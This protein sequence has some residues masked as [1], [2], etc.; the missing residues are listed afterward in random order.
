MGYNRITLEDVRRNEEFSTYVSKGNKVLAVMG[1]TD[2][3][4][5]H[6]MKV[7]KG[8]ADILSRFGYSERE[9]E[10]ARIAGYTHDI[11]NM[12]N[13]ADHAHTGA[14]IA[15]NI[16]T[17][18][19]MSP[20]EIATIVS[21]IGHHDE[22]TGR[23]ISCV[24][25]AIIIA[26]KTDVRRTRVRNK[27]FATFDIHD[28]VNYAVEKSAL[29]IEIDEEQNRKDINLK[30]KL[31]ISI[32]SVMEYFEIFLT[33]MLMCSKAA[34]FLGASFHLYANDAKLV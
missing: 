22:S 24:S 19:N 15:F 20:D 8:A 31:D 3:S 23:A 13:R 17:R 1:Y 26:D 30:I 2:H 34:E 32:C 14:I 6:T 27:D 29:D 5:A 12:V 4:A 33:R 10:L 7:A 28:R 21:A 18:M 16:L 9:I 25:A 11:G